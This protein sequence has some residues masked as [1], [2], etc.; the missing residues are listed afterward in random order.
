MREQLR[1]LRALSAAELREYVRQ[2]IS[3][4]HDL[5][6]PWDV[7]VAGMGATVLCAVLE[8]L[9]DDYAYWRGGAPDLIL[10]RD[11]DP[12]QCKFVEVK[13]ARDRLNERQRAWLCEL[14]RAGAEVEVC[15]VLEG[16]SKRA[17]RAARLSEYSTEQVERV[18]RLYADDDD[19]DD[20]EE[21]VGR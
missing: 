17:R 3:C 19:D 10:W 12:P 9:A 11:A 13:G 21:E 2:T 20:E 18:A 14:Q 4:G 7:I 16:S 5:S 15:R 1:R 8:R 6:L